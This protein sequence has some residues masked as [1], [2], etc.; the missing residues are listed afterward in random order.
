MII[1]DDAREGDALRKGAGIHIDTSA[2]ASEFA[3]ELADESPMRMTIE[4]DNES[5][6]IETFAEKARPQTPV[7]VQQARAREREMRQLLGIGT[8]LVQNLAP[9]EVRWQSLQRIRDTPQPAQKTPEWYALRNAMLTASDFYKCLSTPHAMKTF[10]LQKTDNVANAVDISKG[11]A[12]RHG[13]KY[14]HVCKQVYEAMRRRVWLHPTPRHLI[15]GRLPRR[16]L[17]R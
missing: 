13:I 15:P 16:H 17:L 6:V 1:G 4:E 7:R 3:S 11:R 9:L 5:V 10:A 2:F 12:C 14:E 8:T